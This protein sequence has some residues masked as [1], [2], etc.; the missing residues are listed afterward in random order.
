FRALVGKT[1]KCLVLDLDNTLWG[2]VL[3]EEGPRG[4]RLGPDYPGSAYVEFQRAVRGLRQRGV[5]LD[6]ASK[7]NPGDV[8]EVFATNGN[9]VLR[10]EDFSVV[11]GGWNAKSHSLREIAAHLNIALEHVVFVDDNPVECDEVAHALPAV[12]VVALPA[13][14]EQFVRTLLE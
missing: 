10:P 12:T 5:I 1:K 8:D 7:N 14:P 9:M 11:R 4:I 3:G 2:G 6:I 13:Q